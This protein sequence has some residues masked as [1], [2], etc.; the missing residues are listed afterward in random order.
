[1]DKKKTYKY[2]PGQEILPTDDY[3]KCVKQFAK[4]DTGKILSVVI[5][6]VCPRCKKDLKI[7]SVGESQDC[8]ECGLNIKIIEDGTKI[9]VRESANRELAER[10]KIKRRNMIREEV[11][12][13]IKTLINQKIAKQAIH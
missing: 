9:L 5:G 11:N 2:R 4:F 1:M 13:C 3:I 10:E 6:L 8:E 12:T 7:M